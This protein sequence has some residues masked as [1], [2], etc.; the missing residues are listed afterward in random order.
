MSDKNNSAEAFNQIA[1]PEIED[2]FYGEESVPDEG[3]DESFRAIVGD[4]VVGD[5]NTDSADAEFDVPIL[6][7]AD[8]EA[9]VSYQMSYVLGGNPDAEPIMKLYT[10]RVPLI[11]ELMR[12]H[13]DVKDPIRINSFIYNQYA[14]LGGIY[15]VALVIT[16]HTLHDHNDE[17]IHY[18]VMLEDV[19]EQYAGDSTAETEDVQPGESDA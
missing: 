2:H 15:R 19:T 1:L 7:P 16:E 9:A 8:V 13:I 17:K 3:E 18:T 4:P 5:D 6:T 14:D 10:T 12:F 11:G